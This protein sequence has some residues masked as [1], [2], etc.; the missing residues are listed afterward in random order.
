MAMKKNKVHQSIWVRL[1][2]Q[3]I[4]VGTSSNKIKGK[5]SENII[6]RLGKNL[7]NNLKRAK[8]VSNACI[9]IK[10]SYKISIW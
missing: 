9:L 3:N 8:R 6:L 2:G 7:Y 5:K 4:S 10:K 1:C